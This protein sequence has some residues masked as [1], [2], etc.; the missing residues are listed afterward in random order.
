MTACNL[1]PPE[2]HPF[3]GTLVACHLRAGH[4]EPHSWEIHNRH[5][6]IAKLLGGPGDGNDHQFSVPPI[7]SKIIVRRMPRPFGWQIVGGTGIPDD[8]YLH[9]PGDQT[10]LLAEIAGPD[11]PLVD[12]VAT[13]R[14]A[15]PPASGLLAD[16]P[17]DT[18]RYWGD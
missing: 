2:G 9:E 16:R 12:W 4:P 3:H 17:D 14:W 7:W 1:R 6:W 11:R 5:P 13:Y 8:G 18:Q 15:R 10:Y